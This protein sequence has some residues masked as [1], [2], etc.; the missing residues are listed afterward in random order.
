MTVTVFDYL[1]RWFLKP[2][3]IPMPAPKPE[4]E[5]SPFS[6]VAAE[7]LRLHNAARAGNGEILTLD[8]TLV[9]FAE[10][11]ARKM[12]KIGMTHSRLN[13]PGSRKAENIAA[14]QATVDSAMSAWMNSRGHRRNIMNPTYSLAGFGMV[15]SDRGVPYWCAVFARP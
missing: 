15:K 10:N 4:P 7:L 9:L 5:P 1:I 11:W 12:T 13:F 14:G 2:Q 8:P 3:P 6:D